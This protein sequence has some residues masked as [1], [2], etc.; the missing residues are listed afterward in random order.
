MIGL[1]KIRNSDLRFIFR[2]DYQTRLF[3]LPLIQNMSVF[4]LKNKI[5]R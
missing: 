4:I 3:F 1:A 2:S 5:I